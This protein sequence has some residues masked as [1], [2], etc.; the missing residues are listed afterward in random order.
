M[1]PAIYVVA[2]LTVLNG[3]AASRIV[4][5]GSPQQRWHFCV[6]SEFLRLVE[7]ERAGNRLSPP[8]AL[9]RR[10]V[11]GCDIHRSDVVASSSERDF[12]RLERR[13]LRQLEREFREVQESWELETV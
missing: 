10:T 4:V 7:E 3:C 12:R 11:A 6:N 8:A 2:L 5:A 1:R 9:A 13:R